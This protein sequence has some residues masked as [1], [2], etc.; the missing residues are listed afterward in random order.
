MTPYYIRL[1]GPWK[2]QWLEPAFAAGKFTQEVSVKMPQDWVNLFGP[3][4]G[5]AR[6]TRT[7]HRP[8]NLDTSE[9]VVI[10]FTGVRGSGRIW[11]NGEPLGQIAM[12]SCSIQVDVTPALRD[13]NQLVVELE[14]DPTQSADRGGLYD[15]VRLVIESTN[16]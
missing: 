7:F 11:L 9:R 13:N 8:T 4:A 2:V 12:D 15:V 3:Q 5:N 16:V 1:V 6:F 14:F 10:E